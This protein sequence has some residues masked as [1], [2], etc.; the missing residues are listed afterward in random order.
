MPSNKK[1]VDISESEKEA[2]RERNRESQRRRREKMSEEM[3]EKNKERD[4]IYQKEKLNNLDDSE[5]LLHKENMV[6]SKSN[7]RLN[8][9]I[10]KKN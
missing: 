4:R 5:K 3:K 10:Q 7:S 6:I 2:K 1:K 8:S 9:S